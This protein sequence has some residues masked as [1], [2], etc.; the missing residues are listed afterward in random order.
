VVRE[1]RHITL[2]LGRDLRY[3][4][5]V[6]RRN[7]AFTASAVLTLALGIG[8]NTALFSVFDALLIKTLPVPDPS[9]LVLLGARNNRGEPNREFSYPVFTE[10]RSRSR[11]LTGLAAATSGEG[12]MQVRVPPAT[13]TEAFRFALVSRNFFSLLGVRPAL[14]SLLA[15]AGGKEGQSEQAVAVLSHRAWTTRFGGA[16]GVI[17]A[18]VFVQNVPFRIAGVAAPGF[19]GQVVGEAPDLWLPA[20]QQPQLYSGMSYLDRPNVDWVM[21]IG[22]TQPGASLA[23]VRA[24]LSAT[25]R[26]IEEQWQ[27]TEKAKGLPPGLTIDVMPGEKGFSPLRDRFDI[28]L[29]L[30]M[31]IVALVLV[32]A[33]VNVASLLTARN[34][35]RQGEI[36]IRL[37]IG[38]RP[39]HLRASSWSRRCCSRSPEARRA[40]CSGCGA[41]TRCCRCLAI[42]AA[43]CRST[44]V[45][46]GGCSPSPA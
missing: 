38:A 35:S 13:D 43:A 39:G 37:A 29:R 45:R 19:F 44:C 16:P 18:T 40:C 12:R 3:A 22:R 34:A 20:D 10:L 15:E 41:P 14:G 36:A 31:A 23:Q 21:L 17:G 26:G 9:S 33:C 24:E 1:L 2:M 32:V 28:P 42:A 8:A 5:R 30:L 25:M 4:I 27:G 46:M 7:P 11:T 6:L